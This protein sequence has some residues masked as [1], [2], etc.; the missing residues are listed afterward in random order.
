[1]L[2]WCSVAAAAPPVDEEF[3][4]LDQTVWCPCQINMAKAPIV[5]AP[6]PDAPG[7]RFARIIADDAS[8]GGN[9]CRAK[10]ECPE[11]S[12]GRPETLG[13]SLIK[14]LKAARAHGGTHLLMEK[15]S[16]NRYCDAQT[17]RRALEAGEEG[18]CMQRQELR[19]RGAYVHAAD[20][21]Y[22]YVLRFRMPRVIENQT[23]SLRWVTAQWKHEPVSPAYEQEFGAHWSASPF[24]AQRFDDGVLHVT[25]QEEH[26][27]CMVASA[28][29]PDG[30]SPAWSNGTP[31]YCESTRPGAAEGATCTPQLQV[32][33]GPAPA[34]S[35]PRGQW[36]EMRYRVQANRSGQAVIEVFDGT[37]FIVRVTGKIGYEH[38]LDEISTTKF[39]VGHY[40]EYMPYRH[41]MDIDRI[42]IEP[43][44]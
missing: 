3:G 21:P 18:L 19:V 29:L 11:L 33:Y 14:A 30:S 35:S 31:Q 9:V 32:E 36:V 22:L 10:L 28:P 1:M 6:D 20:A 38:P 4:A 40:R 25:V 5:F 41:A 8:L 26:C 23:D 15:P 27:R 34:L 16:A 7:N 44:Q 13:P 2:A 17:Q 24:L 12:T 39:K 42:R 43:V 37:R